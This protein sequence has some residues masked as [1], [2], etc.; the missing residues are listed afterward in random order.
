M[1][2]IAG[3]VEYLAI[4]MSLLLLVLHLMHRRADGCLAVKSV[5]AHANANSTFERKI[6]LVHGCWASQGTIQLQHIELEMDCY[7]FTIFFP[8]EVLHL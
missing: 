1:S 5:M 6:L 3:G 8:V 2:L 7:P 4:L